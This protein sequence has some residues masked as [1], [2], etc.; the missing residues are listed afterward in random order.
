MPLDSAFANFPTLT[1]TRLNMRQLRLSDAEAIFAYKSNPQ[2]THVYGQE[3][4][5]TIN[6]TLAWIQRQ[7]D[8]YANR[9]AINWCVTFTGD[10]HVIGSCTFWNFDFDSRCVEIGYELHLAYWSQGI[11]SE[12]VQTMI[13]Y[14]FGEMGLNRLEACP[15]SGNPAS[16]ALLLKLGF[17]HEGT[18]RQRHFFHGQFEDQLYFGLLREEWLKSRQV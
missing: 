1:T 4:H 18:L 14:G 10:D 16:T 7:Q 5:Q 3:P 9:D 12:A 8:S 17:T 11:M 6:D 13:D 15:Y 2:V